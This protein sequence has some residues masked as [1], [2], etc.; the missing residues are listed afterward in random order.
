MYVASVVTGDVRPETCPFI[1]HVGRAL[2]VDDGIPPG[3][4]A[5]GCRVYLVEQYKIAVDQNNSGSW[6]DLTREIDPS[7]CVSFSS[8]HSFPP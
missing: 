3:R 5:Y 2:Q 1:L 6:W 8:A 7:A 4:T